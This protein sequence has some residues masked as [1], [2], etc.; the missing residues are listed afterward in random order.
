M[1]SA[2]EAQH[3]SSPLE[4]S[5]AGPAAAQWYRTVHL[6]LRRNLGGAPFLPK[7]HQKISHHSEC[8]V[9]AGAYDSPECSQPQTRRWER[10][11]NVETCGAVNVDNGKS[12]LLTRGAQG[13]ATVLCTAA[14]LMGSPGI[15][16]GA[17]RGAFVRPERNGPIIDGASIIPDGREGELANGLAEFAD[18]T[19]WKIRIV[20]RNG[21]GS[22]PSGNEVRSV[23]N[24]DSRT[25]VVIDDVSAPNVLNFN[26]GDGVREKL[27]RQ[28]FTE[29]QSR[30]GNQFYIAEEGNAKALM[31]TVG[32][33]RDCLGRD[34][35]CRFVPGLVDDLYFLTLACSVAAGAVFGFSARV[36]LSGRVNNQLTWILTFAPLWAFLLVSF[37]ILPVTSRT[38]E[39]E[40]LLK[41]GAAFLA[42][43]AAVYLTPIL[44]EP[45]LPFSRTGPRVE[46]D[47]DE[48]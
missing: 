32:A 7:N 48:E 23:W 19:G 2:A 10:P 28:F 40:P 15:A 36:P 5:I 22:F 27:P 43:G 11:V 3:T 20:T 39:L 31:E 34:K 14:L 44:G 16:Y 41:N 30:F 17:E 29:L 42:A 35:G 1:L 12:S 45:E 37:G 18:Q 13:V 38:T 6:L 25:I 24:L 4:V 8:L 47:D 26:T 21:P 33:L 9:R 46:P